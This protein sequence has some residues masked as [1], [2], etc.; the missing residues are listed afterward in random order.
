MTIYKEKGKA[1][2]HQLN[3]NYKKVN[4]KTCMIT[5]GNSTCRAGKWYNVT[6]DKGK[7][8]LV[9]QNKLTILS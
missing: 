2:M 1:L 3:G 8:Y 9:Y 6:D 7:I 5:K 4:L